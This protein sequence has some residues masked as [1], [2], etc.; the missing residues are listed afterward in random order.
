MIS[1][2]SIGI[3][4]REGKKLRKLPRM[5]R[6]RS[7]NLDVALIPALSFDMQ[8]SLPLVPPQIPTCI[9]ISGGPAHFSLHSFWLVTIV[10]LTR[11]K[12]YHVFT[13][14]CNYSTEITPASNKA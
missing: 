8:P 9:D 14:S 2:K 4:K 10:Q 11:L 13:S 7:D 3:E 6:D 1:V 5:G 12:H